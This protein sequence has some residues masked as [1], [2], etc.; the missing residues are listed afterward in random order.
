MDSTSAVSAL[1]SVL[2]VSEGPVSVSRLSEILSIGEEEV[3]KAIDMLH[4]EYAKND[5]GLLLIGKDG[6]ILLSTKAQNAP[7]VERYLSIEREGPLSR[8][9]L[10]TL[11]IIAYRGPLGRADIEAIRGVNST[12]TLRNLLLRGLIE[13]KG[14]PDDARGYLYEPSL[15]F[16]ESIGLSQL[17]ELP[18]YDILSRDERLLGAVP[19]PLSTGV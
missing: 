11:S 19:D 9:A 8:A 7:F 18:D 3:G 14:N 6:N 12:V 16:L 4:E 2:F 17:S 15:A 13:R 1:E 5:R 10:E